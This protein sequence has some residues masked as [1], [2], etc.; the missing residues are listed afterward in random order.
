MKTSTLIALLLSATPV[1]NAVSIPDTHALAVL[2]PEPRALT[3]RNILSPGNALEKRKGGG[4]KGGGGGGGGS[5]SGGGSS[6][7]GSS[8]GRTSNAGG[9]TKSGSGVRPVYGGGYYGG[10]S[11]KPYTSG[12]R[13]P[14]GLLPGAL[15]LPAAALLVFPG[16]WLWSVY[17]YYYNR[18]YT[19]LNRTVEN[20]TDGL[21][22]TL[23]VVCLCQ[24]F[25]VCGCDDNNDSKFFDSLVGNGSYDALNKSLVTVSMVNDTRSLVINGTLPNGTTAADPNA[26]AASTR[27]MQFS[28]YWVMIALVVYSV[29]FL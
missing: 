7:G 14:K 9:S 10:G 27:A 28:G 8:T 3:K 21:N 4:G 2:N 12:K 19:F 23:P 13:S 16:I 11:A 25:S 18:P 24:E 29:Y 20:A 26:S 17:P 15:L 5:K 6:G 1:I 22:Q